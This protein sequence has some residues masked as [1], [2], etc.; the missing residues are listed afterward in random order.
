[1]DAPRILKSDS[2]GRIE[3]AEVDGRT[4][5]RRVAVGGRIPGSGI[6]ARLLMR[7]EARALR[8]LSG[9]VGVP[10]VIDEQRRALTRTHLDGTPLCLADA[11]P[12]NFFDLLD[13][14]VRR[15]HARGVCHNDLHKEPNILVAPD[16]RPALIDFQIA[17]VHRDPQAR[18]F[19]L[20]A[21]EDLRHIDKHRRRYEIA[22]GCRAASEPAALRS[23]LAAR[24]WRRLVKPVYNFVTRKLLRTRDAEMRRPREG[25]WPRWTETV[26]EES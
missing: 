5:I 11:L 7:R 4:V 1:M 17:S 18:S 15:M 6:L 9:M 10:F 23:G 8:A 20:R 21:A 19:R 12:S 26:P 22:T 3:R 25:P 24:A 13:A 14:L 2:F 16:G